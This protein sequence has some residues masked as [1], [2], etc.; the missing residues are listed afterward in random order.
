M[1]VNQF[2]HTLRQ[3]LCCKVFVEY[4]LIGIFFNLIEVLLFH[5]TDF[6]IRFTFAFWMAEHHFIHRCRQHLGN[7]LF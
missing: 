2:Q 5:D 3:L 4:L 1:A 7:I 6:F